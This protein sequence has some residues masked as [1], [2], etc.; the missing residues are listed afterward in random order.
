[1]SHLL[2]VMDSISR[3]SDRIVERINARSELRSEFRVSGGECVEFGKWIGCRGRG[4]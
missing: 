1:M 2:C 4:N 3:T